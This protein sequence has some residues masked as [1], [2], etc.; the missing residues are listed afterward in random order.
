MRTRT[1]EHQ[2]VTRYI[3]LAREIA[4]WSKD[5]SRGIGAVA[6][7]AKGQVLSCGYNGFPR[8][9]RDTSERLN[10][11]EIKYSLTSHAEMNC[12]YNATYNGVALDGSSLYIWGLPPCSSCAL[13]IIQVGITNVYWSMA[14]ELPENWKESYSKTK[15]L[16]N[17]A[18]L[19][20][21]HIK[22]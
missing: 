2:W 19:T 7:S 5:P 16:F 22:I 13:G 6:V 3:R 8:G 20:V 18:N 12:I 11:R 15:D 4:T 14:G 9:I 10:Q 21:A 1:T 17:E